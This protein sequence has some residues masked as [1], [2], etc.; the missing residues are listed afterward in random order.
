MYIK[1][2]SKMVK[3]VTIFCPDRCIIIYFFSYKISELETEVEAKEHEI[4]QVMNSKGD[5]V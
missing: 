4:G 5:S 2:L 1:Q 3:R